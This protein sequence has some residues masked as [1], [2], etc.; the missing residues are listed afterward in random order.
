MER[1]RSVVEGGKEGTNRHVDFAFCGQGQLK[2]GDDIQRV[3]TLVNAITRKNEV[4]I[5]EESTA[6]SHE[7][8]VRI[9][10]GIIERLG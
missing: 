3:F 5:A 8:D 1:V 7:S 2:C 9:Q 10:R 4:K 6:V